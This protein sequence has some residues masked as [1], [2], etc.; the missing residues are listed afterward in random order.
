MTTMLAVA[1]P[2]ESTCIATSNKPSCAT[3]LVLAEVLQRYRRDA[4]RGVCDTGRYR[5]PYFI[6]GAGPTLVFVPGLC[7]DALS[8][9]MPVSRLSERFRCVAYDLPSGV[10]DGARLADYCHANLVAD[11]LTLLDRLRI[12]RAHLY[13]SS[14]GSTIVLEA[15]RRQPRRFS[16]A[17]LQGGF[18]RRP[19]A[20][21]EIALARFAR[22]WPWRMA[23]LPMREL[24]LRHAHGEAFDGRE[25][26]VWNYFI[27][28]FGSP[29][30]AAVALRALIL[31]DLD[32]CPH[33]PQVTQPV[34]LVCGDRDPLVGKVCEEELLKGLPRAV[35]AEI[36]NCGHLPYFTHPEVLAELVERYLSVPL[37]GPMR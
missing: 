31:N 23:R 16:H 27:E 30:M 5:C 18:A 4:V 9:V 37:S 28:R 13:G 8:Y 22:Y 7:D 34:M 32:L 20:V 14:F 35:R 6:W 24:L 2:H 33:L 17:V 29:P 3:R 12:E 19:L 1:E 25:P 15:L 10:G 21:A 36:E 26:A 11:L